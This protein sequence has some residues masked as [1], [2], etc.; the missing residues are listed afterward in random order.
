VRLE[1]A[2]TVEEFK[3]YMED[4]CIKCGKPL[5]QLNKME[6][7]Q[8]SRHLIKYYCNI[9]RYYYPSYAPN[10][11]APEPK[12]YMDRYAILKKNG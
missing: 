3:N 9:C 8:G 4:R 11:L 10:V 2:F 1:M 5:I 12:K 6:E 7:R